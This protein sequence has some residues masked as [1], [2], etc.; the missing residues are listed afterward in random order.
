MALALLETNV[1]A[2]KTTLANEMT[3]ERA[4]LQIS[5]YVDRLLSGRIRARG[6]RG[7]S[8]FQAERGAG[9]A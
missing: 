2:M 1:A 5:C 6:P 8:A 3:G 7:K 9:F 4:N